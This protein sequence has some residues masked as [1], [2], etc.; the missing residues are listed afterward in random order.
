MRRRS[1][2]IK[3]IFLFFF[4]T[5][6]CLALDL[7]STVS[8]VSS[9]LG[10]PLKTEGD[11][12]TGVMIWKYKEGEITFFHNI[13]IGFDQSAK[14]LSFDLGKR[15]E[16]VFLKYGMHDSK[17][18]GALGTPTKIETDLDIQK[19]AVWY[20][21]DISNPE[22]GHAEVAIYDRKVFAWKTGD[23]K[24][25]YTCSLWEHG[26]DTPLE[27][28]HRRIMKEVGPPGAIV[29]AAR[30][31]E[32]ILTRYIFNMERS[33]ILRVEFARNFNGGYRVLSPRGKR[34]PLERL[35]L[36]CPPKSARMTKKNIIPL[37]SPLKRVIKKKPIWQRFNFGG[38][39]KKK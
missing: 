22:G 38:C 10:K 1:L 29:T 24:N 5:A 36:I 12:I 11:K 37:S 26:K 35:A 28:L 18:S 4:L 21:G 8:D 7:T 34:I 30:D 9:A 14:S 13:V 3:G 17:V 33:G 6:G 2:H 15:R 39:N 27:P 23:K 16:G 19:L 32:I 31:G 20:Y 25:Y